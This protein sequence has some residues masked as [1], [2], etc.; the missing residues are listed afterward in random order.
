MAIQEVE[1][2][3]VKGTIGV[4]R[5][6]NKGANGMVM[7]IVQSQQ[8]NKPIP[9]TVRELTSNAVDAQREKVKAIQ[10]L[11][12]Q[13]KVEDYFITRDGELY[14]DSNWD[15]SYYDVNCLDQDNNEVHLIYKR[16]EGTGRCD[17]FIVQDWGVGLG[18]RRLAGVLSI[19][20]STKRNRKDQLGAFGIG[21]KV[22]LSTGAEYYKVVSVYNGVKYE[23]HVYNRKI[24]SLIPALDLETGE[25]NIPYYFYDDEGNITDTIYGTRT[26]EKNNTRIEVPCM[27]HYKHDFEV[28]VKT[29]LNLVPGVR[30]F[31]EE[32][33]GY[34]DEVYF[35]SETLYNSENI[36]ITT[37]SPYSKPY[38]A[39][40]NGTGED[41][42]CI[43]YGHISFEEME[44]E[45]MRG[46]IGIKCPIRQMMEDEVTGEEMVIM[47][48]VDVTASRETVRWT[49]NTKSYLKKQFQQAQKEATGLVEKELQQTDFVKWIE[50]CRNITSYSGSRTTAIG[51]ISNIVD[52]NNLK[53]RFSNTNIKFDSLSV[54]FDGFIIRQNTKFLDRKENKFKVNRETPYGWANFDFNRLYFQFDNT[55]RKR[56]IY[57]ADQHGDTFYTIQVKSDEDIEKEVQEQISKNLIKRDNKNKVLQKRIDKR[58]TIL[59]EIQKSDIYRV[60]DDVEVPEEYLKQLEKIE[61]G[62]EESKEEVVV[63]TPA[64]RRRL[65]K[66]VVANTY[67]N[68]YL[69]YHT[70]D[71]QTY[72]RDKVEPKIEE[73]EKYE[74]ILYY[75]NTVDES[76][77]HCAMH[78]VQKQL[79]S[80]Y[81]QNYKFLLVAK[82]NTKQFEGHKHIDDFFGKP[83]IIK[84]INGKYSG[85]NIMVDNAVVRWYTGRMMAPYMKDLKFFKNF[86]TFAPELCKIYNEVENYVKSY[87]SDL[88]SYENR[89]GMK[90]HYND[91]LEFLNKLKEFQDFISEEREDS[92]IVEKVK[93]LALPN[94]SKSTLVVDNNMIEKLD[95]LLAYAKPVKD[96]FNYIPLLTRERPFDKEGDKVDIPYETEYMISEI[97]KLKGLEDETITQ[98]SQGSFGGDIQKVSTQT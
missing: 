32:T 41:Q 51:K 93:E 30:F 14:E 53:P 20:Y 6:I 96:L 52:L 56:D 85:L 66:R 57:L 65:E 80:F 95:K 47:D 4:K 42:I 68:R 43:S 40:T 35:K 87:H 45:D 82:N 62:V 18:K 89:F 28:A 77:L 91:F 75:G 69:P 94:D 59:S 31:I 12:G 63:I 24:N 67:T 19:G 15:P 72:Q 54:V 74:G 7:D 88:S 26:D 92:E 3:E 64:E 8:Y 98:T 76:K 22:G 79:G 55:N 25:Q 27:K 48:G 39:V 60:Y 61:K 2:R 37:S 33:N 11:S 21:A 23:V 13:A 90:E 5:R 1:Q 29:Q 10:I 81:N 86:D 84:D 16:G 73:I 34:K 83:E 38:V 49:E 36:V 50:A 58:N 46:D 97:I 9:S 71:G 78:I 44:M 17:R 70:S